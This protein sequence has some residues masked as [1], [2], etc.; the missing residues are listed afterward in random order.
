M[1]IFAW[2]E[3]IRGVAAAELHTPSGRPSFEAVF[4][5]EKLTG[6]VCIDNDSEFVSHLRDRKHDK[7]LPL[8]LRRQWARCN[9]EGLLEHLRSLREQYL[10][11]SPTANGFEEAAWHCCACYAC[12]KNGRCSAD[13]PF[14][15][16]GW[17][18]PRE[19]GEMN[20]L[21]RLQLLLQL[22]DEVAA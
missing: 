10:N 14:E 21:T 20:P 13:S 1:E 16:D 15:K 17:L 9:V 22:K 3:A 4:C 18:L 5:Q 6:K 11:S 8:T 2:T 19:K 7:S 12:N